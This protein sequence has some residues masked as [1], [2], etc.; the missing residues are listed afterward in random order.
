MTRE[1]MQLE[2][3]KSNVLLSSVPIEKGEN[4]EGIF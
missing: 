2:D 1:E 3:R 4:M